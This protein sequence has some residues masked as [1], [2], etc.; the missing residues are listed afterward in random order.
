MNVVQYSDVYKSASPFKGSGTKGGELEEFDFA[1]GY[2][3]AVIKFI[4]IIVGPSRG[5]PRPRPLCTFSILIRKEQGAGIRV[6]VGSI[7][8]TRVRGVI[9]ICILCSL[10]DALIYFV[11]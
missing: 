7:L 6:V 9:D 3:S 8:R 2:I 1:A 10:V 5:R 11:P 4:N